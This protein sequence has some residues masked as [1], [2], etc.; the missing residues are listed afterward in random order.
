VRLERLV[1][2]FLAAASFVSHA[3]DTLR[4]WEAEFVLW[5][6]DADQPGGPWRSDAR[7][8]GRFAEGYPDDVSVHFDNPDPANQDEVMWVTV[9]DYHAAVDEYLGVLLNEPFKLTTVKERDNVVFRYDAETK[10]PNAL[11]S[12]GEYRGRGIPRRAQSGALAQLW[13]GIRQY[14]LGNHG[15]NQ[16]VIGRCIEILTATVPRL[17]RPA[18]RDDRYLA[19]F[20][21]GRCHAEAYNTDLAIESFR[22][23]LEYKPRDVDTHMALLAEYSL[24]VHMAPDHERWDSLFLEELKYVRKHFSDDWMVEQ[25]TAVLFDESQVTNLSELSAEELARRR[26]VGFGVFRWKRH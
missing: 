22:E 12:A 4:P 25:A 3:A 7:L 9:I 14:R 19:H 11:A 18:S 13:E 26:K 24:K 15:N 17:E 23:A 8:A 21:L 5:P 20:V 1:L 10:Q 6:R 16:G 2:V